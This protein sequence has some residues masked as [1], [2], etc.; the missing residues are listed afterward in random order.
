MADVISPNRRRFDQG[1]LLDAARL[2]FSTAG[3]EAAQ[4]ADMAIEAGTTRATL[5]ARLGSKQ[6]IYEQVLNR[7]AEIFDQWIT[8]AYS[9]G[10]GLPLSQLSEIGMAPIFRFAAERP[11]GFALLFR[12][13]RRTGHAAATRR[14]VIARV[15]GQLTELIDKRQIAFQS[16][17][18]Q[19]T[20]LLA[21]A[22][23][24]VA[25]NICEHAIDQCLDLGAAHRL[26]AEFVDGALRHIMTPKADG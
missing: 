15:T 7:E 23:V 26:A 5:H 6:D 20:S 13:A 2:V 25:V 8:Q 22:C 17:L 12:G 24:G 4:T 11:E 3:Y 19:P 10:R 9:Q 16:D 21:A 18:K 1:N 14:D